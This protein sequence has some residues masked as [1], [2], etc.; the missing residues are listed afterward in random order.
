M[1][2]LIDN[3]QNDV[4]V[5]LCLLEE[6]AKFVLTKEKIHQSAEL[7]I[8]LVS[9]DEITELNT[10]YRGIAIATDVLAFSLLEDSG[11]IVNPDG[12]LPLLL[13]DV[14][15]CPAVAAQQ[16]EKIRHSLMDELY[17][18]LVHGILHLLGRNHLNAAQTK[19][20]REQE[21]RVLAEF[22]KSRLIES[23]GETEFN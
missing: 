9:E 18:L 3:C 7:S 12:E 10:R 17:H 14:V 19:I 13:G 6:L 11:E 23:S 2:I 16:A 4:E 5:D 21:K 20:M 1:E 22:F 8:V 15:I